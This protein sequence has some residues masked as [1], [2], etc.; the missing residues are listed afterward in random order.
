MT[1]GSL[2]NYYRDELIDEANDNNDPN[3][4]VIKAKSFKYK[5]SI[6]GNTYNAPEK[7][8]NATGQ[9][10]NNPDYSANK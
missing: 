2:W 5:T 4:N 6:I 8:P 9:A 3:K 7:S 10:I 1:S